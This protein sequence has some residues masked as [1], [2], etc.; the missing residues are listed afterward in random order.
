MRVPTMRTPVAINNV[1]NGTIIVLN[2][3]NNVNNGTINVI[4]GTGANNVRITAGPVRAGAGG[5]GMV[6]AAVA[7]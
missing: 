5:A 1:N 3:S 4:N 2:G 6:R 7:G